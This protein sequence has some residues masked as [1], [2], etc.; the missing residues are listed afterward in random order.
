MLRQQLRRLFYKYVA[1]DSTAAP[2]A[3]AI[4]GHISRSLKILLLGTCQL[5]LI[6]KASAHS[7]HKVRHVLMNA[8]SHAPTPAAQPDD[9]LVVVS[10]PLRQVISEATGLGIPASDMVLSRMRSQFEAES[11]L[12]NSKLALCSI[13]QR[14]Q[15]VHK[16]TPVVFTSFFEPSSNYIGTLQQS[17]EASTP[18]SIVRRL[19]EQLSQSLEPYPNFYFMDV[20]LILN[21]V[22]REYLQ[23]DVVLHGTHASLINVWDFKLD[24]NRLSA[25]QRL[26]SAA[27]F[28]RAMRKYTNLFLDRLEEIIGIIE[29]SNQVK[30]IICDL[31]DT[32]WRGVAAELDDLS[33]EDRIAGWPLGLVEAL[34]FFKARGGILALCS[35]NDENETAIRFERIF[36]GALTLD[37]FASVKINWLPKSRN[38]AE[39]LS[40]TNIL[41]KNALFIDDNAREIS[42][43]SAIHPEIRCLGADHYNWRRT[44]LHAPETQVPY[45]TEESR[46]RTASVRGAAERRRQAAGV[47]HTDAD[48]RSWLELL[49]LRISFYKIDSINSKYYQR[50]FELLN[51]TNQ[52]NTT[53]R[54]WKAEE[55]RRFIEN[56]GECFVANLSDKNLDNGIVSVCMLEGAEI[57]QIVLSCRVFGL[58]AEDAVLSRAVDLVLAKYGAA[59]ARIIDSGRNAT[60]HDFFQ[61]S[62]FLPEGDRFAINQAIRS[63]AH[64]E[65]C[66]GSDASAPKI[67]PIMGAARRSPALPEL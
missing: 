47:A 62:G 53:G 55:F 66:S 50:A 8:L 14:I 36:N 41:A 42:E 46:R 13:I 3:P 12:E 2:I 64:I 1:Y 31:D 63:P 16:D 48:R 32:L 51:K 61:S 54:R 60:C 25:P 43:V 19:N 67:R 37:D 20:N 57:I 23:D 34:L 18:L 59:Y 40:E 15:R 58:G 35:K 7:R 39:I 52:F 22:G 65:I 5:E 29:Q 9:D 21:Y 45:I 17:Y 10:L 28:E 6:A 27:T 11:L 56:Q 26:H 30:L 33:D 44:L 24:S 4:Q 49:K 38:V